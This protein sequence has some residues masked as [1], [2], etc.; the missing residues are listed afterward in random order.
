MSSGFKTTRRPFQ[1]KL[2]RKHGVHITQVISLIKMPIN[3]GPVMCSITSPRRNSRSIEACKKKNPP[4]LSTF[5]CHPTSRFDFR[6]LYLQGRLPVASPLGSRRDVGSHLRKF[7]FFDSLRQSIPSRQKCDEAILERDVEVQPYQKQWYHRR[8]AHF[9]P[10]IVKN[11]VEG[12]FSP[13][14]RIC[15]I[16]TCTETGA[17]HRPLGAQVTCN[18]ST[19]KHFH[20][21]K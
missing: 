10:M 3:A 18:T 14:N 13:T 16:A 19:Q 7:Q 5:P 17:C 9:Q 11:D 12:R 2:T 8:S 15:F 21:A 20:G 1:G 4:R 6:S